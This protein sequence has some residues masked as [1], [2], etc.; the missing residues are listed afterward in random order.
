M[1]V[2]GSKVDLRVGRTKGRPCKRWND[3]I[4]NFA[5]ED[6]KSIAKDKERWQGLEKGFLES[7]QI[8]VVYSADTFHLRAGRLWPV[9]FFLKEMCS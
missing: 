3:D 9:R 5:G 1:K 4:Q 7:F 8:Y 2:D 6:W